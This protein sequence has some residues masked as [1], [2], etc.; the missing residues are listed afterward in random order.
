[1][2]GPVEAERQAALDQRRGHVAGQALHHVAEQ[3]ADVVA[4]RGGLRDARAVVAQRA[5]PDAHAG[6]SADR[7]HPARQHFR[8]VEASV[9]AITRSEV[10]DF[11]G[12]AMEVEQARHQHRRIGQVELFGAFEIL[13]L[14]RPVAALDG[15]RE[16][17]TEAG[18]GIEP[19]QAAPDDA[20]LLVDQGG[21]AAVADHA[22]LKID[23][24]GLL[25][26]VG[27]GWGLRASV[28][29]G[30]GSARLPPQRGRAR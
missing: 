23:E 21:D 27:H 4:A 11:D 18:V 8:V 22:K 29:P 3:V 28:R 10:G 7:S 15:R 30:R 6:R 20:R 24:W 19:R 16:Q 12:T 13:Q 9:Q 1:M 17:G 25:L 2:R 14:D 26:G 5:H